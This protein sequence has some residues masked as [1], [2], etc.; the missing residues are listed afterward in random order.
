MEK[1]H[2]KKDDVVIVRKGPFKNK[3]GKVLAILPPKRR[4]IVEGVNYI[5]KAVRP[6]QEFPKGQILKIEGS[7]AIPNLMLYCPTC[8][9]GV[10]VS[11]VRENNEKAKRKCKKC[12]Y[13]FD[14]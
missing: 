1:F 7:I 3:T 4:A 14:G 5:H 6:S 8:K 9:K 13:S 2:I 12:G 10:K 11:H